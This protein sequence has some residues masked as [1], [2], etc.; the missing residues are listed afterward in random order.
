MG[1]KVVGDT[2]AEWKSVGACALVSVARRC[3][4]FHFGVMK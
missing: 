4:E 2:Q 1:T 3:G